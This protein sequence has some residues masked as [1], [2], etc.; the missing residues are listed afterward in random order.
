MFAGPLLSME[1]A[2]R[3][4]RMFL[5]T[6]RALRELRRY[7]PTITIQNAGQVNIGSQQ[8]NVAE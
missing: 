3:W 5:R 7:A 4:N 2:E 8:L 1:M 6:L